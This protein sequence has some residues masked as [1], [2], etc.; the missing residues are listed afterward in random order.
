MTKEEFDELQKGLIQPLANE[1]IV[2]LQNIADV[3]VQEQ[4]L[5]NV[6]G[7]WL[8]NLNEKRKEVGDEQTLDE[9]FEE[10]ISRIRLM[11]VAVK[12]SINTGVD[13]VTVEDKD[14]KRKFD[15]DGND[16]IDFG[17]D[18]GTPCPI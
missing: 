14:C 10:Y 16:S 8:R 18:R 11:L 17:G 15:D 13:E 3:G 6:V 2:I 7:N 5:T 1:I 9:T 4:V 12:T